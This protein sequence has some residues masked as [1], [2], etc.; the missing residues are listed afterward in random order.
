M[1]VVK[2]NIERIGGKVSVQSQ[3]G[4]GT[5][6]KMRIPLTLAIMT[7]LVVS[8]GP[9]CYAIPQANVLELVRLD[10][11]DARHRI[12]MIC[13]AP[14]YRLRGE[15]LPLLRLG[16]ELSR[17]RRD[18]S[19]HRTT[20]RGA[21]I[22]VLQAGHLK[23]GLVVDEVIDTQEIVVKP[24]GRHA[25]A[26]PI[27]AG[28]T[29]MGNGRVLLIL[30]V[31]GLAVRADL[32]SE[33]RDAISDI[34]VDE[35]AE[36]KESLV[37]FAGPD[38]TRMAIPLSQIARLEEFPRS[39]IE[40][41]GDHYIVQYYGE[42]LRL[43][44]VDTLLNARG[45]SM[46]QRFV[47]NEET[48]QALVCSTAGRRVGIV[49]D[50]ILDTVEENLDGLGVPTRRGVAGSIVIQGRVTEVLDLA[51]PELVGA[52]ARLRQGSGE[53]RRS[54]EDAEAARA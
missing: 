6:L 13:D 20:A 49:V 21:E 32:L 48:F 8:D 53:T 38:D 39:S 10:A 29:V 54:V 15:L 22:V 44:G 5:T 51:S 34:P 18:R 46:R 30:D 37:L 45:G 33:V 19:V 52:E 17:D 2:T 47:A 14:V 9:D 16:A 42:L 50:R 27:F 1:D 31:A 26:I 23:F 28:A 3:R 36:Q 41:L 35:S 24:L 25:R 4:L 43:T 40:R 7:A 11:P 12:E